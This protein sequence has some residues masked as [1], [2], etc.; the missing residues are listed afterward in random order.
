VIFLSGTRTYCYRGFFNFTFHFYYFLF[1]FHIPINIPI[2][3]GSILFETHQH[4]NHFRG[5][6]APLISNYFT[7]TAENTDISLMAYPSLPAWYLS[8]VISPVSYHICH[9]IWSHANCHTIFL[10]AYPSLPTCYISHTNPIS[11][12]ILWH[13]L[14]SRVRYHMTSGIPSISWHNHH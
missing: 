8:H 4:L 12:N 2:N 11:Y 13:V 5:Q 6:V 3:H 1:L 10:V 7:N 9:P 14:L